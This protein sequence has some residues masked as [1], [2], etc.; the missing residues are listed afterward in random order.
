M[1]FRHNNIHPYFYCNYLVYIVLQRH[2]NNLTDIVKSRTFQL[3]QEK[4]NAI[5]ANKTKSE[6]LTVMS[7]EIRTPM[8][9]VLGMLSLIDQSTLSKQQQLQIN[10]AHNSA[11]YLLDIINKANYKLISLLFS[12]YI[13]LNSYIW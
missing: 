3:E 5:H 10:T 7:H 8:N 4:E 9:G 11:L 12:S 1:R 2:K 13:F 6:F